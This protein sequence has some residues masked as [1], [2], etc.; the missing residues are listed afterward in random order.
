MILAELKSLGYSENLVE[1]YGDF[2][3]RS[4]PCAENIKE[5]LEGMRKKED[6]HKRIQRFME[7]CAEVQKCNM[8]NKFFNLQKDKY[9]GAKDLGKTRESAVSS[10]PLVS[11][12]GAAD[13]GLLQENIWLNTK[14][15]ELQ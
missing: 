6:V 5:Q 7:C 9:K 8:D 10:T 11:G 14:V 4:F 1:D 12:G 15:E 2:Y 13:E 3:F